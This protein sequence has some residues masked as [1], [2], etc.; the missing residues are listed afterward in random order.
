MF[1]TAMRLPRLVKMNENR[2]NVLKISSLYSLF[3][4]GYNDY[5]IT[6]ESGVFLSILWS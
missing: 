2:G 1:D 5:A 3:Q 4:E 6:V